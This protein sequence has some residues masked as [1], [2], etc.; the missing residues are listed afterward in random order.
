ML[1]KANIKKI[2]SKLQAKFES[3]HKLADYE[4]I[5]P[6]TDKNL[7]IALRDGKLTF[8]QFWARIWES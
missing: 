5:L 1:N 6:K 8:D 3:K 2:A 7:L 4:Y